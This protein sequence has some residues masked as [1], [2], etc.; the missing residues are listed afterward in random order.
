MLKKFGGTL[1]NI[2]VQNGF[3]ISFK[4]SFAFQLLD[5]SL[6]PFSNSSLPQNRKYLMKESPLIALYANT[7]KKLDTEIL[8]ILHLIIQIDTTRKVNLMHRKAENLSF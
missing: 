7:R 5:L 2:Q 4:D 8:V 3:L 6:L 1:Q